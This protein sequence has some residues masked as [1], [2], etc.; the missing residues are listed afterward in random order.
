MADGACIVPISWLFVQCHVE[1]KQ[2]D[3]VQTCALADASHAL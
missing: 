3:T 1:D 2:H